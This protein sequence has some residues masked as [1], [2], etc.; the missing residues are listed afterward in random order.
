MAVPQSI[1]NMNVDYLVLGPVYGSIPEIINSNA[2]TVVYGIP[3]SVNEMIPA[4]Q[5]YYQAIP[6]IANRQRK[7]IMS[8]FG[9]IYNCS[10]CS[11]SRVRKFYGTKVYNQYWLK[12]RPV[13]NLIEEAKIFLKH[14]T[15]LVALDDDDILFS[16]EIDSWLEEFAWKWKNTISIPVCTNVTPQTVLK[17]SDKALET[18]ALFSSFCYMGFQ[19]CRKESLKLFNR[20]FQN[21]KQ[22]KNAFDRLK[23]FNIKVILQL[24]VGLPVKDPVED[25]LETIC[26]AQRIANGSLVACYPLMLFPGTDLY[27]YCVERNVEIE[28]NCS[29]EYYTGMGSVKFDNI[30]QKRI[31]NIVKMAIMFVQHNISERYMRSLIDLDLDNSSS[32]KLSENNY[33]YSLLFQHGAEGVHDF[34]QNVK[35]LNFQ[36]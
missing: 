17:V 35:N 5:E 30:T 14:P 15:G 12:R 36:F 25:A 32:R 16:R 11:T 28:S 33:Y 13:D 34:D 10:Y 6:R 24:I 3:R 4:R 21:E 31:R 26:A 20:S 1:E 2:N 29:M 7:M 27:D 22:V 8:S 18:L 19:T 9:C 23:E